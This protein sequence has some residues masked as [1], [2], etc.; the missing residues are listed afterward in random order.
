MICQ[1]ERKKLEN[2]GEFSFLAIQRQFGGSNTEV[3]L[4]PMDGILTTGNKGKEIFW[5]SV[6]HIQN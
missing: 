6:L 1:E 2:S 4:D 3:A 5:L